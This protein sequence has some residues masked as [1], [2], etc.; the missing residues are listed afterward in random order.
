V[1]QPRVRQQQQPQVLLQRLLRLCM[2]GL[3]ERVSSSKDPSN[4]VQ[5][6]LRRKELRCC[7]R[8]IP[9]LLLPAPAAAA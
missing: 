4:D 3:F 7:R 9:V 6:E 5:E 8:D 2:F 1:H